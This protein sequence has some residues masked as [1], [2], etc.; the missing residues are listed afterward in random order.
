MAPDTS[1]KPR[2]GIPYR[3]RNEEL[4]GERGKYDKYREA[5][6]RAGGEPVEVSLLLSAD[7]LAN[8]QAHSMR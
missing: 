8:W 5:V 1:P 3:T 7:K 2:V 4:K 6:V